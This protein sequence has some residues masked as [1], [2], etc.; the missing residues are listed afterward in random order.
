MR[1]LSDL[2][3]SASPVTLEA[4][5]PQD[6]SEFEFSSED[7]LDIVK[8][9]PAGSAGGPCGLRSVHLLE[10]LRNSSTRGGSS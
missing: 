2:Y 4:I 5:P 3:P 1:A 8:S 7:V 10:M 9:F 6:L